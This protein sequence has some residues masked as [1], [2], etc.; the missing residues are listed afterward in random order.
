M[1]YVKKCS[2]LFMNYNVKKVFTVIHE[3]C[4]VY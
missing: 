3:L 1:N 2:Q 4:D